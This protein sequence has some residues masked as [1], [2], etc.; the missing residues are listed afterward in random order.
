MRVISGKYKGRKLLGYDNKSTRPTMDRIKESLFASIQDYIK[1]SIVLDLFAG[2]GALGIEALSMGSKYAY[3]NDIDKKA[4]KT[5]NKNITNFDVENCKV[6][7][8]SFENALKYFYDEHTK[9]NIIFLDPPY[10]SN[11]IENSIKLITKYDLLNKDGIIIAESD[12]K[13][14]IIYENK[15]EILKEK[16]YKDKW[17]V[18]LKL[19]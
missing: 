10:N 17:V 15:Y 2:S 5:I 8:L 14:K 12:D 16:K 3:F 9:F 1:D 13:D 4:Y 19:I 11:Y 6:L 7:N 18:I